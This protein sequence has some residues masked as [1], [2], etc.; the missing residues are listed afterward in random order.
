MRQVAGG[1]RCQ[2]VY[3]DSARSVSVGCPGVRNSTACC[4]RTISAGP[5]D[6]FDAQPQ[7]IGV[8]QKIQGLIFRGS[9]DV[10]SY[11]VLCLV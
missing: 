9:T 1:C 10:V 5:N 8:A 3:H 6:A 11:R 2:L 7:T 4:R